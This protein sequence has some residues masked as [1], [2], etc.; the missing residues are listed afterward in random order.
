[1]RASRFRGAIS[2]QRAPS[3]QTN[4]LDRSDFLFKKCLCVSGQGHMIFDGNGAFNCS[5]STR[6]TTRRHAS[7][8]FEPAA[9]DRQSF[10]TFDEPHAGANPD[11][12]NSHEL[13]TT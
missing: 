9:F 6:E 8:V 13:S 3:T 7:D 12:V 4:Q 2:F 5:T 1:M 10:R 11:S